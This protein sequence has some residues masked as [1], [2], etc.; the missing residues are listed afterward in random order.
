MILK[1]KASKSLKAAIDY[2]LSEMKATLKIA[3]NLNDAEDVVVQMERMER[4]WGKNKENGRQAYHLKLCFNPK[5][6]VRNG[7]ILTDSLAMKVAIKI[8][9][10]AFPDHQVVLAVHNDTPNKHVYA[11]PSWQEQLWTGYSTVLVNRCSSLF[12]PPSTRRLPKLL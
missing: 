2:I 7:G 5:D 11:I 12:S 8:I 9:N 10:E 4:L 3:M 1:M 6:D